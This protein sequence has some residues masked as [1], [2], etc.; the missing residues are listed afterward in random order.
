M[1]GALS[2]VEKEAVAILKQAP[3]TEYPIGSLLDSLIAT[4]HLQEGDDFF[5]V[6]CTWRAF[7]S[8]EKK[9]IVS[10]VP[11]VLTPGPASLITGDIKRAVVDNVVKIVKE[12]GVLLSV[13]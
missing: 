2:E 9:A 12:A 1:E 3:V 11:Q 10:K 8:D 4:K 5:G 13:R 6:P 7:R